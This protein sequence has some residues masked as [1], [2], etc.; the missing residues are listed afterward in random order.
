MHGSPR[1]ALRARP[2]FPSATS[3]T[4]RRRWLLLPARPPPPPAAVLLLLLVLLP[5][6]LLSH[7]RRVGLGKGGAPSERASAAQA[8]CGEEREEEAAA[9]PAEGIWRLR[10]SPSVAGTAAGVPAARSFLLSVSELRPWPPFFFFSPLLARALRCGGGRWA[11]WRERARWLIRTRAL[12]SRTHR[13]Q[14]TDRNRSCCPSAARPPERRPPPLHP[15][16]GYGQR[17]SGASAYWSAPSVNPAAVS[18]A[19]NPPPATPSAALSRGRAGEGPGTTPGAW[20]EWKAEGW[21]ACGGAEFASRAAFF[22]SGGGGVARPAARGGGEDSPLPGWLCLPSWRLG[23]SGAALGPPPPRPGLFQ[24]WPKKATVVWPRRRRGVAGENV[25]NVARRATTSWKW[26]DKCVKPGGDPRRSSRKGAS[27]QA[28]R[29]RPR[30]RWETRVVWREIKWR[31]FKAP[32]PPRTVPVLSVT[33]L[34]F[35]LIDQKGPGGRRRRRH[36]F[37]SQILRCLDF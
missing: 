16:N 11:G 29:D 27:V 34:L 10:P 17:K 12:Q 20:G 19:S 18:F 2:P 28:F 7:S 9:V 33:L 31:E 26:R 25:G 32:G 21:A 24:A 3:A 36:A 14:P 30:Y 22:L 35:S 13:S 4:R 37:F 23:A 15:A 5:P 8:V 6:V 1:S